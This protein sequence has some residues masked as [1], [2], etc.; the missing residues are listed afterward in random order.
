M[1]LMKKFISIGRSSHSP[2]RKTVFS[3]LS[4]SD[5]YKLQKASTQQLGTEV[6]E[7]TKSTEGKLV[8]SAS[9]FKKGKKAARNRKGNREEKLVK[10][11]SGRVYRKDGVVQ[12]IGYRFERH[13]VFREKGVGRGAG[14]RDR[15]A[16]LN[17]RTGRKPGPWFNPVLEREIPSLADRVAKN[18]AEIY[19]ANIFIN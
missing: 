11:I 1:G 16:T 9:Q 3:D 5:H 17:A 19:T 4:P 7:W 6:S 13:G 10:S 12:R 14:A 18:F 15:E 8:Q 2:R